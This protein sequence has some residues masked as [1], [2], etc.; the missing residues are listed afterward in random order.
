MPFIHPMTATALTISVAK[1]FPNQ[2]ICADEETQ[3]IASL[4]NVSNIYS[5][6]KHINNPKCTIKIVSSELNTLNPDET[7]TFTDPSG[8]THITWSYVQ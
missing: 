4:Y 3:N 6:H 1:A 7:Y 2:R 8:K 5:F